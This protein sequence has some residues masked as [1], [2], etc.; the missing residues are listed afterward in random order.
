MAP[1]SMTHHLSKNVSKA[2]LIDVGYV[3]KN[4]NLT[5]VHWSP[6]KAAAHCPTVV[7]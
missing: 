2:D 1:W 3:V 4:K 6:L 7:N 5:C